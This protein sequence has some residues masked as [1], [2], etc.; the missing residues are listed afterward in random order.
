MLDEANDYFQN[1]RKNRTNKRMKTG[2]KS[3]YYILH[4]KEKV[5]VY[6]YSHIIKFIVTVSNMDHYKT[7]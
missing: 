3:K 1:M 7:E 6:S 2:P 4:R 5:L